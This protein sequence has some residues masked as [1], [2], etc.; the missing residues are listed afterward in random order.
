VSRCGARGGSRTR[1][2][3]ASSRQPRTVSGA[4]IPKERLNTIDLARRSEPY[5]IALPYG[6]SVTVKPL[7]TAGPAEGPGTA[8][9]AAMTACLAPGASPGPTGGSVLPGARPDR[10]PRAQGLGLL[11]A[12]QQQLR[13]A[14]SAQVIGIVMDAAL[15]MAAARG[16][17]LPMVAELPPAAEAGLV[18]AS[19]I[20][21]GRREDHM[22]RRA[23]PASERRT[24]DEQPMAISVTD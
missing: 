22:G 24:N 11:L 7:T 12:C 16:H 10:P 9:P 4:R 3:A 1:K 15:R 23:R 13:L 6:L 2:P 18:A 19:S 20:D 5:E 17:D 8:G 21:Q 14:P